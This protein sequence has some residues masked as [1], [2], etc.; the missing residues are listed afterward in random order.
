MIAD[1]DDRRVNKCAG[2]DNEQLMG[3]KHA[4]SALHVMY[5][6]EQPVSNLRRHSVK[7]EVLGALRI[8]DGNP[9]QVQKE[10]LMGGPTGCH[11]AAASARIAYQNAT[12]LVREAVG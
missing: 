1:M 10:A 11:L 4:R 12:D 7:Q 9:R 5:V 3:P 8:V 2:G 6:F